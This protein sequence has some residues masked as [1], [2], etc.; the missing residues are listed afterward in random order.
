MTR[1][2]STS[3]LSKLATLK[4]DG[5]LLSLGTVVASVNKQELEQLAS[6]VEGLRKIRLERAPFRINTAP[7]PLG[8]SWN[9]ISYNKDD[10]DMTLILRGVSW[11]VPFDEAD[12]LIE[13][14]TVRH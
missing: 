9:V 11:N 13:A 10:D 12:E 5:G 1:S 4:P 3:T 2:I 7:L 14:L 6:A 8:S